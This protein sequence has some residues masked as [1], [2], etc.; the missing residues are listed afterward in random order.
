MITT[1]WF[2][3]W[4]VLILASEARGS[5]NPVRMDI[6]AKVTSCSVPGLYFFAS[7]ILDD[8]Y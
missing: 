8:T 7:M 3:V 6:V 2:S 1:A 4:S 5:L